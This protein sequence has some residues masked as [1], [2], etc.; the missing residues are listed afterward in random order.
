M[1]LWIVR[2]MWLSYVS[3]FF[4]PSPMDHLISGE[5]YLYFVLKPFYVIYL[6]MELY[7]VKCNMQC[8]NFKVDLHH[9]NSAVKMYSMIYLVFSCLITG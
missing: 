5:M 3:F 2:I 4:L 1:P 8:S 7:S 9:L 6:S